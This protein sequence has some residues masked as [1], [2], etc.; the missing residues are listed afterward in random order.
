MGKLMEKIIAKRV[1]ANIEAANLLPV[2]QFRSR[3]YYM[4]IDAIATLVHHIQA[5]RATENAGALLLFDI[6]SFFDNVNPA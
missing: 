5:T 3:A 1:N 4:A 6:S 2:M